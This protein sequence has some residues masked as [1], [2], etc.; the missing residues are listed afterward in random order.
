MKYYLIII[1]FFTGLLT[2]IK[3]QIEL[4]KIFT[5]NMVLP[6]DRAIP[7]KG[8]GQPNEKIVVI[9]NDQEHMVKA[10]RNGHFEVKLDPMKYGGPYELIFQGNET[11]KLKNILVGDLW[12]CSG[13]SNMQFSIEQI[14]Y[15]E[16]DSSKV[17]FPKLRLAAV[18]I[19]A[20]YLPK[21][22]LKTVYW[23]EGKIDNAQNFSAVAWF[24]GRYL[25]ENQ[26]IPI[27][28][29][30][31]NLGATFIETWMSIKALKRFPQFD[32]VTDHISTL[33]K[34]F[35][36]LNMEFKDFRK[37]WDDEHYL[38]GVG[39]REKWY[40]DNY[41]DSDWEKC[42]LPGFWENFGFADH[43]GSFWFRKSFDLPKNALKEDFRLQLSQI[44]DYDITWVNGH[45]VGES[46][47]NMNFRDYV[48]PK[49]IL[50]EKKNTVA[51]RVFDVGG[52]GGMHTA[53]FWGS[54]IRN[55]EWKFKKG[56]K[57]DPKKFPTKEVANG[58]FFS[59]PSILYN[60]NIAPLID[61]PIKGVIWYQGES[62]ANA[63]RGV[64]YEYLL[65]GLIADWRENWNNSELPFY[66]VQLANYFKENEQPMESRWAELRESQAKA[67]QLNN[68]DLITAVDIGNANDI[69][70]RNK[71]DV[72]KR[73]AKLA[74]HYQYEGELQ[75]SPQYKSQIIENNKIIIE[76]NT[77]GSNLKCSNKYGYLR[78]FSIAGENGKFFW[79]KAYIKN[80]NQVAVYSEKVEFPKFVRYAWADNPGPLDLINSDNL[81]VIPFR[82]DD[83]ETSTEK[84]QY[85]FT[86]H[87]F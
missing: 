83:F 67:A 44:D 18:G 77:F 47:G 25:T 52:K 63:S 48:V 14:K 50:R 45:K 38:K 39:L 80:K 30:S 12:L 78:G 86:P 21:D 70:P 19:S 31:V 68:V 58:S 81:P 42:K 54:N 3:A 13:Q 51:I 15:I 84:E 10:D 6:R 75:K 5:S 40:A 69:H 32:Q 24:F 37:K 9:I 61:I 41:D 53:Y 7:I 55:G 49:E 34:N 87:R 64:E 66:I 46:F 59:Y 20:D 72:G 62:N 8:K 76:L 82:T 65:K 2:Q 74:M 11:K 79:A 27:G 16:K 4:P 28:L 23:L 60:G 22:D 33:N 57:I 36:T 17:I 71:K 85:F 73:L 26:E 29:L 56:R 35:E 43:D 1:I